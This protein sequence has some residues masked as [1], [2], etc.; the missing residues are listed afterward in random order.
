MSCGIDMGYF[1][2]FQAA[3]A[4]R[5]ASALTRLWEEYTSSDSVDGKD[6]KAIL[7]AVKS[8][9]LADYIGRHIER[10]LPIWQALGVSEDADEIL[11][12]IL[13]LELSNSAQ[14]RILAQQ[15][16]DNKF[17][18]DPLHQE[19]MRLVGLRSPTDIFKGCISN[20]LLLNHMKK[21][22]FVFHKGGW[23]VG[24]IFD[25]SM[26]REQ[27]SLEFDYVQG[28]KDLSF[29]NCFSS[30]IPILKTHFLAMRFGNPD[31]LEAR[32]KENPVE[33]MHQLLRD[34]GPKTAAEIKDELCGLV[35]PEEEW[36]RWWQNTRA[37]LKK[38]K[39]VE[40]PADLKL[41]FKYLEDEVAHEDKLYKFLESNPEV[42]QLIQTVFSFLKD[43]PETIKN[44]EFNS[45]VKAKL[46]QAF[47]SESISSAQKL[48]LHFL[49]QDLSGSKDYDSVKEILKKEETPDLLIQEI[50][51]QSL[52]KRALVELQKVRTDWKEVFLKLLSTIEQNALRDYLLS[53]LLGAQAEDALKRELEKFLAHPTKHPDALLWY[54]QKIIGTPS[55][56]FGDARGQSRF[57]EAFLI[58]L[59]SSADR[60]LIKKM[61]EILTDDRFALVRQ[62]FKSSTE[63]EVQ[64]FLLL[65]TKCHSF[66]DHDIKI[67]HSLAEVAHPSL[68][69]K[70]K[71]KETIEPEEEVIW[72]TQEGY[73][74]V[75]KRIE[76]IGTVET[77]D[78]AKEIEIARAHGDLR[79][80]A[81]FKA[82]LERRDRLQSELKTLSA[83]L[84]KCRVLT[85]DDIDTS[86]VGIGVII[87]CES[88]KGEKIS[89]MLLGPWDASV[90]K[91][92]LSFQ[93]KLAK[94]MTGL[95]VGD[96]FDVQGKTLK[97]K[98]IRSAL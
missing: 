56:P 98:A 1:V 89:Y 23:G 7:E 65:V 77:V 37:K 59:G 25:V 79:E 90:E 44:E 53:E 13:D 36:N 45:S 3:L 95:K 92:I 80:N 87:D 63:K 66:T 35:I 72:T 29:K 27:L 49:I 54:F 10:S 46:S 91:N 15:F 47:A 67:L 18:S 31:V 96:T 28:R 48:E 82:A 41:P 17:K 8:S 75:K 86:T 19:K 58:L 55:L 12:L 78:N 81:E 43:F 42:T 5:D 93:S 38:D 24:E 22:N 61:Q 88:E 39:H 74:T 85:K 51:I 73:N 52:K 30:L 9:D 64:E 62:I 57:F 60:D 40:N 94:A 32:A 97:I 2:D 34:L 11:R 6:F 33:V 20:Y 26:I 83:Q 71:K 21:G 76:Q 16:L 50:P 84:G 14:L 69:K 4:D 70:G 68:A